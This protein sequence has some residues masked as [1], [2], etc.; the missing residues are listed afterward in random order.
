LLQF[1]KTSKLYITV[2]LT[3]ITALRNC[4]TET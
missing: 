3:V 4:G 1:I 2:Q